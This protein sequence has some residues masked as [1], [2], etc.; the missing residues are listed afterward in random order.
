MSDTFLGHNFYNFKAHLATYSNGRIATRSNR[1]HVRERDDAVGAH[2]HRG[3]HRL[4]PSA[5]R[6]AADIVA[7]LR[8]GNQIIRPP[9]LQLAQVKENVLCLEQLRWTVDLNKKLKFEVP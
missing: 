2:D 7:D 9:L 5:L 4:R 8:P 1:S 6:A 3:I